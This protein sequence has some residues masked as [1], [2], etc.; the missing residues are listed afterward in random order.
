MVSNV[1]LALEM[2]AIAPA[3]GK[4]NLSAIQDGLLVGKALWLSRAANAGLPVAPTI[5]ISRAAWNALQ[6][7]RKAHD[8][9]LRVH[10]VATLFR[11]G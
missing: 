3:T 11:L 9:R 5:V 10:W 6:E 7:E 8:D 1:T 2:F 4:A